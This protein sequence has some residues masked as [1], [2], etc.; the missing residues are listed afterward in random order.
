MPDPFIANAP[1]QYLR[2]Q[3]A[4]ARE[5]IRWH[6]ARRLSDPSSARYMRDCVRHAARMIR[7][8]RAELSARGLS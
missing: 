4:I 8:Y 2:N 5:S 1:A 7:L 3:I 6:M